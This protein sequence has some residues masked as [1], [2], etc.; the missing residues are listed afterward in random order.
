[1]GR[2]EG[3]VT[4]NMSM[5]IALTMI[6]PENQPEMN[7]PIHLGVNLGEPACLWYFP[8]AR[9]WKGTESG[10]GST[11][12]VSGW[13]RKWRLFIKRW[14]ARTR[15]KHSTSL[16]TWSEVFEKIED[17]LYNFSNKNQIF[18]LCSCFTEW[19]LSKRKI[20][21]QWF[22]PVWSEYKSIKFCFSIVPSATRKS[23]KF[24]W[25]LFLY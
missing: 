5:Q 16:D 10:L 17:K 6:L 21:F 14:R 1:M 9:N 4:I 25:E 11:Y 13:L 3:G 20:F 24:L 23:I 12:P 2:W 22:V 7:G 19:I 15:A 18:S 8:E